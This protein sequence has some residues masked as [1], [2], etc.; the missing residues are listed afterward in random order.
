[1]Q[2]PADGRE[3][4]LVVLEVDGSGLTQADDQFGHVSQK[5]HGLDTD[6]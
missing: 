3:A 2:A 6:Q 4:P 5:L 1:M